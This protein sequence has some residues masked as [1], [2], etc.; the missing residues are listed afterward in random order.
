MHTDE[1]QMENQFGFG[2]VK[3]FIGV[4]AVPICG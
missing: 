1:T 3:N 2:Q 4:S